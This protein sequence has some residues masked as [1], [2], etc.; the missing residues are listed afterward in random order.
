MAA[1]V[2]AADP[3]TGAQRRADALGALG[4]GQDR[5]EC[6][7]GATQCPAAEP[8]APSAVVVVHVIAEADSLTED[9]PVVL[10]GAAEPDGAAAPLR[11]QT[12][13]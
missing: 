5:L 3:R 8:G 13:G 12:P 4:R 10:D 2:C 1:A 9:S 7:C 6:L 11:E